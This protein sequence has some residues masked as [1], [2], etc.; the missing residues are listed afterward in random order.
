MSIFH[1]IQFVVLGQ[2]GALGE[3]TLAPVQRLGED[4][5]NGVAGGLSGL[6]SDALGV[7]EG[8]KSQLDNMVTKQIMM[9]FQAS[10]TVCTIA[11]TSSG[12]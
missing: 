9:P 5:S 12:L 4:I 6:K 2:A 3:I 7:V 10:A 1:T 8:A 11:L